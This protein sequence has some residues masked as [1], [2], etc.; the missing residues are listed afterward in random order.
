M[1]KIGKS[2]GNFAL[3]MLKGF[4]LET[5]TEPFSI[6]HSRIKNILIVI[7][8]QMG[9]MLCALPMMRSIRQFYPQANIILV[10]KQSTRFNEIFK[11][12]NSPA[13][14]VID[15]E[16]GFENFIN[17]VK[18]LR[19]K[20][21]DLA[22]IP[23]TVTFSA[24]NHLIAYYSHA[25][26]KAGVKSFDYEKNKVSYLLNVKNDFVWGLKKVHQI[27]RN[28][29]IIRQ[30]NIK[31][32]ADKISVTL[33][34]SQK[35][36]AE[37]FLRQNNIDRNKK[38]VGFHPGAAKKGNVWAPA[39]FA[40]LGDK[41]FRKFNCNILISEGPD[42]TKYVNELE[43]LLKEKFNILQ[44]IRHKGFLMNNLALINLSDLFITNDTG[45]MHLASGL[46]V[47]EIALFGPTKAYEW[48]P[49]G[50]NKFSVQSSGISID[51]I[52]ID[53]VYDAALRLM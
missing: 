16:H 18:E 21:I 49:V 34:E 22:I 4:I 17:L 10:T 6:D 44:I 31:P 14:E 51:N 3:K 45:I 52:T 19:D 50:D 53:M 48:G 13:D 8:H 24:T 15:F 40:E 11:N 42:D 20:K 23:S 28:L 35:E 1:E 39:K 46:N 38:L 41:L 25:K 26:I 33:T 43:N 12:N 30:I 36:F 7:R 37:D 27:E 5:D 29:D 9:D 47:P 32:S 2:L